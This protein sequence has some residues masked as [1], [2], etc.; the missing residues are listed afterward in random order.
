M[1]WA[2]AV[3]I[4]GSVIGG[5]ISGN[6]ASNA[7]DTQAAAANNAT[8]VQRQM[9]EQGRADLMPWQNAGG[10][11]LR[12]L[13]WQMGLDPNTAGGAPAGSAPTRDQFTTQGQAYNGPWMN[14]GEQGWVP[15][16]PV[17]SS[18][19]TFDQAGFDAAT[20]KFN[21]SAP[22]PFVGDP[23]T[24]GQLMRP[25]DLNS[26]QADPG[27][28]FRLEQGQQAI[29]AGAAARGNYMSPSTL[30]E[31]SSFSQDAASGEFNNAYNR[32]NLNLNNIYSRLTG[33][34]GSGENAA[35]RI[36][37]LGAGFG[38]QAGENLIG[39]GNASAAGQIGVAGAVNQGIGNYMNYDILSRYLQQNNPGGGGGGGGGMPFTPGYP[40]PMFQPGPT[41]FY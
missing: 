3:A 38:S 27:F 22:T 12:E 26:F 16:G 34:S 1:P 5:A 40:D 8:E 10:A 15:V 31:L 21:A 39:A 35:G 7:A 30:K 23:A 14:N 41:P 20:A 36:A 18:A 11:S 37:G 32:Y 25:F 4:G 24:R 33:L 17:A 6:A 19:P 9:F 28:K 2:A 29:D 13:M